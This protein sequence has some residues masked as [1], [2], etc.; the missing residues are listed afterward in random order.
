M[1]VRW[2]LLRFVVALVGLA[3]S[4]LA[5]GLGT[6]GDAMGAKPACDVSVPSGSAV[7]V[8]PNAPPAAVL[9]MFAV[10]SHPAGAADQL[11]HAAESVSGKLARYDA[12]LIRRLGPAPGGG[13]YLVT[14]V[15]PTFQSPPMSCFRG[16]TNAER[17]QVRELEAFFEA[18]AGKPGYCIVHRTITKTARSETSETDSSCSTF[19][20]N[21][22]VLALGVRTKAAMRQVWGLVPDGVSTIELTFPHDPAIIVPASGNFFLATG[23]AASVQKTASALKRL[24]R[25]ISHNK[26]GDA[27]PTPSQKRKSSRLLKR[28]LL[29]AF[30]SQVAWVNASGATVT[31]FTPPSGP[32]GLI[33]L[34]IASLFS[35]SSSSSSS[36]SSST[37]AMPAVANG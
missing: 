32:L 11:T 17:D 22:S 18:R 20:Q 2:T 3:L 28:L 16:L 23:S 19:A 25:R 35:G 14:G 21:A 31:R 37:K 30:P 27:H 4:V 13:Y 6:Q 12:S 7:V 5:V 15:T 26:F 29:G 1:A 34:E 24:E 33:E 36:S 9:S 10:L 8:T